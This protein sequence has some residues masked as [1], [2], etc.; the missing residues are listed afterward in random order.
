[1]IPV[2]GIL[3]DDEN[4]IQFRW[5]SLKTIYSMFFLFCGTVESCFGTRRLLRLGFNI[6]SAEGLMFFILAMVRAFIFFRLARK[7]KNIVKMW[8]KSEQVFLYEPYRV[9]GVSLKIKLRVMFAILVSLGI[10]KQGKFWWKCSDKLILMLFS[11]EHLLYL[12]TS[13]SDNYLQIT[14]CTPKYKDFW[15]NFLFR[16]R[17]H[18]H[19]NIPYSVFE[20]PLY[21]VS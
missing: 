19:Y 1:M 20:L 11:A 9:R 21:E 17:P 13:L 7:W 16:N 12:V 3:S 6:G 15:E 10:S 2:D 18:L 4:Q 5:K 14:Q 8:R